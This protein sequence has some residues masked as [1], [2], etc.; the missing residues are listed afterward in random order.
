MAI[1][2][3]LNTKAFTPFDQ[4]SEEQKSNKDNK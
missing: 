4:L 2:Y 3:G 1:T